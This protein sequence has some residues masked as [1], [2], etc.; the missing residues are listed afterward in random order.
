MAGAVTVVEQIFEQQGVKTVIGA[1]PSRLVLPGEVP[2]PDEQVLVRGGEPAFQV[3]LEHEV[4][5]DGD[6]PDEVGFALRRVA[7]RLYDVAMDGQED[8]DGEGRVEWIVGPSVHEGG[9]V[10]FLD[11]DGDGFSRPMIESMAGI[12]VDELTAL[13]VVAEISGTPA[14]PDDLGPAW[15]SRAERNGEQ[16]DPPD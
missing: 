11:T 15:A 10:L 3:R 8:P 12:F 13:G 6:V 9:L 2:R 7:D 16:P 14:Y 4:L 5:G 1:G